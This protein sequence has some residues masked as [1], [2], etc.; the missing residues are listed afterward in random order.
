MKYIKFLT[1]LWFLIFTGDVAFSEEK[2]EKLDEERFFV[3]FEPITI[4][5]VTD[6]NRGH[7]VRVLFNLEVFNEGDIEDVEAKSPKIQGEVL[8]ALYREM[9]LK[10]NAQKNF[11]IEKIDI[12]AFNDF[13]KN[14][15]KKLLPKDIEHEVFVLQISYREL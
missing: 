12:V 10:L 9:F 1:I 3:L 15:T 7:R 11:S 14:V 8:Q 2:T 5:I 13:L 4:P 6:D